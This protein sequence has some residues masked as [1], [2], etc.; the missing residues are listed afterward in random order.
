MKQ[1]PSPTAKPSGT[2]TDQLSPASATQSASIPLIER[3]SSAYWF[4]DSRYS[5]ADHVRMA[6]VLSVIA[7]EIEAWAPAKEQARICHLQVM[8]IAARLRELGRV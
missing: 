8:E 5:I 4:P 1:H 7:D 6:A 2:D 3:C